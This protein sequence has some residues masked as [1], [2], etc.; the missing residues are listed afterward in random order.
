[1]LDINSTVR[2]RLKGSHAFTG[3]Y[4]V[5]AFRGKGNKSALQILDVCP[6]VSDVFAK[7]RK[8]KSTVGDHDLKILERFVVTVYDSCRC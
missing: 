1:M 4:V 2:I 6:E 3:C 5:S 7:L 8:F